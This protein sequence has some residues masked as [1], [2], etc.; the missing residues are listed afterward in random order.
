MAILEKMIDEECVLHIVATKEGMAIRFKEKDINVQR[1]V[2][3]AI[4]KLQITRQEE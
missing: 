4:T 2:N 3:E 1:A